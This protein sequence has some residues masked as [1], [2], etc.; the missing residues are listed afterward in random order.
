MTYA[1]VT[2][3]TQPAS[4]LNQ[5]T[6]QVMRSEVKCHYLPLPFSHSSHNSS[7]SQEY[8][9]IVTKRQVHYNTPCAR[10]SAQTYV[11]RRR[12]LT[13]LAKKYNCKTIITDTRVII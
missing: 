5:L 7:S 13:K 8:Y 11:Y 1:I 9:P 2:E 12:S 6:H 10:C 4:S 3:L